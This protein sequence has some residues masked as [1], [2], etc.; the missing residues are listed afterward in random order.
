MSGRWFVVG[1][2]ARVSVQIHDILFSLRQSKHPSTTTFFHFLCK[3]VYVMKTSTETLLLKLQ[4][5]RVT[6]ATTQV[7]RHHEK[8]TGL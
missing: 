7:I 8:R 4:V 3:I 2:K 6:M 5:R 1:G